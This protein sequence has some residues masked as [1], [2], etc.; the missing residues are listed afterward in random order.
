MLPLTNKRKEG[1][2]ER[3]HQ[4]NEF[5]RRRGAAPNEVA[6]DETMLADPCLSIPVETRD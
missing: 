5:S 4:P 1:K 6:N 3:L 2:E